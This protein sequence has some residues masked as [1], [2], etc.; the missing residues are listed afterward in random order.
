[1][2]TVRLTIDSHIW[3]PLDDILEAEADVIV[4]DLTIE[5]EDRTDKQFRNIHGWE[6]L[7]E[8]FLLADLVGDK[9]KLPRGYINDLID[10]LRGWDYRVAIDDKR[11]WLYGDGLGSPL[12]EWTGPSLR[13]HQPRAVYKMRA[14]HQGIYVAPTGSGKT[15]AVIRTLCELQPHM[16]II[17]VGRSDLVDQWIKAITD[18][19][20]LSEAD[21]GRI[22]GKEWSEGVI[23]V[24][25]TQ[26]IRSMIRR[27][28]IDQSWFDQWS[29]AKL[30]E[31]HW[32]TAE[33]INDTMQRYA[34]RYRGGTSATPAKTGHFKLATAALGPIIHED[35]QDELVEAGVILKPHVEIIET[36]HDCVFW[37]D[38]RAIKEDKFKCDV[39]G[40]KLS[41]KKEHGHRNNYSKVLAELVRDEK[42]N[43]L[44]AETVWL[45]DG[46]QLV[47]SNQT[48]HLNEIKKQMDMLDWDCPIY[49]LIGGSKGKNK[50]MIEEIKAGGDCVILS[51]VAGEGL[52]IP[53][54]NVV[55]LVF[56]GK[57]PGTIKQIIGRG[58]R[59]AEG[60]LGCIIIDYGD[61]ARVFRGQLRK[62][63]QQVY[64]KM[65]LEVVRNS[66]N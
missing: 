19:T 46:V 7:P 2:S 20:S 1:M 32:V 23:T 58:M 60:K 18:F 14:H 34:S 13:I 5:N 11:M 48:T 26:S 53:K 54:L 29:F 62:R 37:G 44:I 39:P 63:I 41:G 25:T 28:E 42:R 38:H 47:V 36:G 3:L 52:D 17:Q 35:D 45:R 16:A 6:D 57:N 59:T 21:V 22:D 55:H 61:K 27:G 10:N 64:V 12:Y 49:V 43:Q 31:C 50:A 56:P 9:L 30:D 66:A 8:E 15:V 24:A 4:D 33:T 65:G 51:T 40:C